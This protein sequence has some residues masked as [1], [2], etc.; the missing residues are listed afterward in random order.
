MECD[1]VKRI[2]STYK[3]ASG[4][5]VN[6]QKPCIFFSSNCSR[7]RRVHIS[8]VLGISQPLDYGSYL[9]LPSLIGRSKK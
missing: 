5:T 8:Y 1:S 2:L 9:G 7:D 6:F 3:I 4:Q